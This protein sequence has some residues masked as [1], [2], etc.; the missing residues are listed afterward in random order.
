MGE[1]IEE[2]EVEAA[3]NTTTSSRRSGCVESHNTVRTTAIKSGTSSESVD[4]GSVFT[5]PSFRHGSFLPQIDGSFLSQIR[6][7]FHHSEVLFQ[8]YPSSPSL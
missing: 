6:P 5:Q 4:Q 7:D 8:P 1:E 2:A 3:E